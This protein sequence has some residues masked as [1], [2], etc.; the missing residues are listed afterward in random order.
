MKKITIKTD[1][2]RDGATVWAVYNNSAI[3][4][5]VEKDYRF[6]NGKE[7]DVKFHGETKRSGF[8]RKADAVAVAKKILKDYINRL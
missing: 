3:C 1:N 8:T 7:Y 2:R 5:E 6:F 4:V